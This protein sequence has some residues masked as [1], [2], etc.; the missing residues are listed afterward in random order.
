MIEEFSWE[1]E[2]DGSTLETEEPEQEQIVY[3]T[4]L[5]NGL[6][7]DGT[8]INNEEGPN[9]KKPAVRNRL[10]EEPSLNNLN[11]VLKCTKNLVVMLT[12]LKIP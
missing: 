8:E 9:D 5:K 7:K 10:M 6:Q 1:R 4:N 12:T 2:D 3:I 11:H